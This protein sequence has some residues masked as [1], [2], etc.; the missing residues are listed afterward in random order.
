MIEELTLETLA[1]MEPIGKAFT[2]EANYPLFNME[3][4]TNF[5][6]AVIGAKLGKIFAVREDGKLVAA[7][8]MATTLDPNSGI[9]MAL[10]QFWYVMPTHRKTR[11]GLDLFR[12]FGDEG[13]RVGAKRLVMVHL[14]NLTPESLH[15]FYERKGYRLV[16]QTFWKEI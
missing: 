11:V 1:D 15:T 7:L 16:E 8:G 6:S 5:W 2:T 14:A 10:E 12:A 4:F 9:L 3:A 13:E